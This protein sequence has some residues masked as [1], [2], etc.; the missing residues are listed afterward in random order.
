MEKVEDALIAYGNYPS[1]MQYLHKENNANREA[2]L[3]SRTLYI[4]GQMDFL[5]VI[6][7]SHCTIPCGW[8]ARC[9]FTYRNASRHA[10]GKQ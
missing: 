1:Q 7:A 9:A 6:T 8:A 3:L 2:F 5:N 10:A 4:N